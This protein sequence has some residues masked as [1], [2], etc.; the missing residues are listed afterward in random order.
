M[1]SGTSSDTTRSVSA[2]PNTASLK[3]SMR[4]TSRPRRMLAH[5]RSAREGAAAV[6]QIAECPPFIFRATHRCTA[7]S[8][9]GP[10]ARLWASA[11]NK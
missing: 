9:P 8:I 2:K 3:P 1:L 5:L 6:Q 10:S 11:G 4:E 7:R